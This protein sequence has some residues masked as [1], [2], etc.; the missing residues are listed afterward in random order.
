MSN[1]EDVFGVSGKQ[2]GSYVERKQ[3]DDQFI[4]ALRTDKQIIVY[5]AS[6]Q[7][8]TALAKK[9]IDYEENIVISLSPRSMFVCSQN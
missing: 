6:K 2:V 5:G 1:L 3:V 7:G 4:D 8:K 9:Y